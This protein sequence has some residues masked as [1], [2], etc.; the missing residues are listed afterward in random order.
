VRAL[1][2]RRAVRIDAA[3]E[4][5]PLPTELP[6]LDGPPGGRMVF[7]RRTTDTGEATVLGRAYPVDRTWPH[8]LVR[9]ELDLDAGTLSFHR[10]RR[11]EP[12]DQPLLAVHPYA[13]V[14]RHTHPGRAARGSPRTRRVAGR[15]RR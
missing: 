14:T 9:A 12:A 6:R 10:L 13:P 5:R 15:Q 2:A 8:R 11:R 4:R 3:P 7:L 1:R